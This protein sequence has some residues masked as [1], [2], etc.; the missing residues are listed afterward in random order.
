MRAK[1]RA[2]FLA[3]GNPLC[4]LLPTFELS[5][6]VHQLQSLNTTSHVCLALL[7]A[8]HPELL[9][10]AA[11]EAVT[12]VIESQLV[13]GSDVV[14]LLLPSVLANINAVG[15]PDEVCY[16]CTQPDHLG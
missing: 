13:P 2:A 16:L 5:L 15:T 12:L 1:G 7:D 8:P 4:V 9:Q 3:V 10:V 6:K 11:I 14:D